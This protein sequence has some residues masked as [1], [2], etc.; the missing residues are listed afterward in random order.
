MIA[1]IL[2]NI[3]SAHNVGSMFRTADAAG[4]TRLY[5]CGI[6]PSPADMLGSAMKAFE[7]T[8]LGA[9]KTVPWKKYA[10]T[11]DCIRAL[12]EEGYAVYAAEIAP[13]AIPYDVAF[14]SITSS[15]IAFVVGHETEGISK[16]LCARCDG[17][18]IIPMRGKKESLNVSVAFGVLAFEITKH[19]I[20]FNKSL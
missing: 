2:H 12:R 8:A 13:S 1:A 16:A 3:R 17:T 9:E 15:K 7:K 11:A 14:K 10:R 20:H 4:I 19:S 5:L 18:V 6:T